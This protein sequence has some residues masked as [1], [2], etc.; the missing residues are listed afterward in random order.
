MVSVPF[1]EHCEP[2]ISC[3]EELKVILRYVEEEFKQQDF[4]H[5]E[6]RPVIFSKLDIGSET[7]C[8]R[9]RTFYLHKLD[10]RTQEPMRCF[11]ASIRFQSSNES[12]GRSE[13]WSTREEGLKGY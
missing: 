6:I 12:V 10:L 11:E 1:S 8:K 9:A 2:L 5:F 13:F 4:G 7:T 3:G